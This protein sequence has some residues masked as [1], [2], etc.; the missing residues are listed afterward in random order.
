MLWE[1]S[2]F[3]FGAYL[4][5]CVDVVQRVF[6]PQCGL[7]GVFDQGDVGVFLRVLNA[8]QLPGH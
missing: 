6:G 2:H 5:G 3:V 1:T 8:G 7:E 4:Q